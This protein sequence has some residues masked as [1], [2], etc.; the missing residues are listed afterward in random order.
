MSKA[1]E[2][3]KRREREILKLLKMIAER[4]SSFSDPK[5]ILIGGYAL[6]AFVP[7]TRYTRDCDFEEK[8]GM[9]DRQA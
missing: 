5:L 4:T 2:L 6:R 3:M 8:Q 1:I 7:F 9:E